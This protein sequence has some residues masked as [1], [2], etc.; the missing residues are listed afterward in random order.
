MI[1]P[2]IL[3]EPN[4]CPVGKPYIFSGIIVDGMDKIKFTVGLIYLFQGEFLH[5]A[6]WDVGL[7]WMRAVMQKYQSI[8]QISCHNQ[9]IRS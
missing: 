3:G 4:Y 9:F 1:M 2:S 6:F 5:V 7:L 8:W